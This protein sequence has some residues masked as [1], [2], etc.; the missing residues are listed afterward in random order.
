PA[1][2]N[3]LVVDDQQVSRDLDLVRVRVGRQRLLVNQLRARGVGHV[4]HAEGLAVQVRDEEEVALLVD[5]K[6]VAVAGEVVVA[7]QAQVVPLGAGVDLGN[8]HRLGLLD[9]AGLLTH[10]RIRLL[11][12][13]AASSVPCR[14]PHARATA[15]SRN[16]ASA[17]SPSTAASSAGGN[18]SALTASTDLA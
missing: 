11:G 8:G 15:D 4:Q 6:A 2:A 16:N 14:P 12:D 3:L 10:G 9:H 18:P 7:D 13:R 1:A 17:F 5:A